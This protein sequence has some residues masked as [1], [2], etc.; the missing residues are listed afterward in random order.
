M[1][2]LNRQSGQKAYTFHSVFPFF[3]GKM[4]IDEKIFGGKYAPSGTFEDPALP[5]LR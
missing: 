2:M 4:Q 1:K 3:Y 5:R